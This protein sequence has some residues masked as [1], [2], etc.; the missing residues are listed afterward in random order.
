V[1]PRVTLATLGGLLIAGLMGLSTP[2][3]RL[4]V[5]RLV[6][7]GAATRTKPA[8]GVS[9]PTPGAGAFAITGGVHGLY[10]GRTLPLVLTVHSHMSLAVTVTSLTTTVTRGEPHCGANFVQVTSFSGYLH[11]PADGTAATTVQVTMRRQ[12]PNACQGV[13]FGFSYVGRG[14]TP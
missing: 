14:I 10:P 1:S 3:G 11:V 9:L 8:P 13:V 6:G 12:A 5:V 2:G 4:T 7:A